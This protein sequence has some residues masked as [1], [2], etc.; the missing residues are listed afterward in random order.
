MISGMRI[1]VVGVDIV[2]VRVVL[3]WVRFG[4]GGTVIASL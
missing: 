1:V 4:M 3:I 2:M